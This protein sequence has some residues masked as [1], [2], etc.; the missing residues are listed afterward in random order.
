MNYQGSEQ[1]LFAP[2]DLAQDLLEELSERSNGSEL[3]ESSVLKN[4]DAMGSPIRPVFLN[5]FPSLGEDELDEFRQISVASF[6]QER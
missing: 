5:Q 3:S 2:Q 1:N 4:L 6:E